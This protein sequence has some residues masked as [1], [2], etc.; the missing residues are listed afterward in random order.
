MGVLVTGSAG[1]IGFHLCRRL[2]EDGHDVVGLD[3]V[4]D[5]YDRTLKEARLAILKEAPRFT[6]ARIDLADRAAVLSLLGEGRFE[7]VCHL[8]AQAGV[9]YGLENPFAY[10][11]S[12]L[13][14]AVNL[15]EGCVRAGVGHLVFASTSSV[16]GAE[17]VMP[18]REDL[19]TSHPMSLYAATKKAN[20]AVAHAYSHLHGL[21]TTGLRFFTVYGPWGRP[22]MALFKWTRRILA[23]EPIE[24]YNQGEMTRDFTYI[25]DIVEGIV[26]I[27]DVVP[28]PDPDWAPEAPT[29]A[30]SG[31]APFRLYNIGRGAPE[32]LMAFLET[33][34]EA[35]GRKARIEFMAMQPGDV[36][37]TFADT[38]A[39]ERV[40]GYRPRVG[41]ALGV[42]R[43]VD[44]YRRYYGV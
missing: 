2:L 19:P 37:D 24:V 15:L 30:S 27:L 34:E 1:F 11:D 20:E 29:P 25:D 38:S 21:P 36:V 6:E 32:P 14:G 40:T 41:I 16:Y 9:R 13:V 22:D 33:L 8:A 43:F 4:N 28:A 18:F 44:W 10:V 17:T 12:N 42:R 35:L 31:V 3:C 39:L 5:Y 26:R 23:G 7:R